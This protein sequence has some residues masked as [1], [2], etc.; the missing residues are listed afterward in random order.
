MDMT[1]IAASRAAGQR[2]L[3]S[4]IGRFA[5]V[6]GSHATAVP[7][8]MLHK[9]VRPVDLGCA[10]SRAAVV[11]AAQGAKR[12]I[13]AGHAYEYDA[14]NCLITSIDLPI[15]SRVTRASADAPYLCLSLTLDPQRI[16][17]LAAEMRLPEPESGPEGE[18]IA[19]A[20]LTTPL[21]DAALRLVRL[22]D[23]PADIPVLAPL[24]EKEMLYRLL[25]SAQG[26][27][28]RHMAVAGSQTHRI[29][30]A[31][32]WIRAHFAEPMRVETLAN[33]VNMSVSSLHHHFKHVTT[34]SPLQYQKQLRLHEARRL[35]L[36][37]G[38][39]VGSV[40]ASVGYE[41]ASQFSRE[42][43]RLFG[44]PPMRDVAHLRRRELLG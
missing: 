1:D 32:E 3:A 33:A 39:D 10:V 23:T 24:I 2:E 40:A 43:S 25:T 11:I 36:Q 35:L 30:R 42:Y 37:Q 34:L 15:L 20:E 31:I 6:D 19:L 12:V 44:A 27:R 7:G 5:P 14:Q 41:S 18:G 8:L 26:T 28:L 29:A 38:G 4:L 17:E 16:V 22:L 9:H 21:L 13:V